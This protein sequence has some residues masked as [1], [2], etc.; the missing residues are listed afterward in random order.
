MAL[1]N[2]NPVDRASPVNR[3]ILPCY[4][5]Q[6]FRIVSFM[7]NSHVRHGD[8][9]LGTRDGFLTSTLAQATSVLHLHKRVYLSQRRTKMSKNDEKM[10]N[11]NKSVTS[12]RGSKLVKLNPAREIF[13]Y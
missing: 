4:L 9:P 13:R 1:S 3:P 12:Y 6:R 10:N 8:S 11:S 2:P 7:A 5:E